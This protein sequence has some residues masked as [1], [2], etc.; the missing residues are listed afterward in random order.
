MPCQPL[1]MTRGP[2]NSVQVNP[3]DY[4]YIQFNWINKSSSVQLINQVSSVTCATLA[5]AGIE[6]QQVECLYAQ[7]VH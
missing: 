3:V 5:V 7:H 1:E 2:V 6:H 4:M